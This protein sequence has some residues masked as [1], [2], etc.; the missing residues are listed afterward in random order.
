MAK[1]STGAKQ[2]RPATLPVGD[3]RISSGS[4]SECVAVLYELEA[5]VAGA[6]ALIGIE[7][8]DEDPDGSLLQAVRLLERAVAISDELRELIEP[9]VVERLAASVRVERAR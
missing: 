9:D 1:T 8:R 4:V 5:Q 2:A 7:Y 6:V 3:D